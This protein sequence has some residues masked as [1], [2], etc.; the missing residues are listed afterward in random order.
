[1]AGPPAMVSRQPSACSTHPKTSVDGDGVT[2]PYEVDTPQPEPK[3]P[4][5][6]PK[7]GV[8]GHLV[9][10]LTRG[11]A[12]G[13]TDRSSSGRLPE[14]GGGFLPFSLFF[15]LN[16]MGWQIPIRLGTILMGGNPGTPGDWTPARKSH[17]TCPS[18]DFVNF[19][20]N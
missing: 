10:G 14:P 3:P 1:M 4:Q 11:V 15:D 8:G 13:T 5:P 9:H 20:G 2:I 12:G 18:P 6:P 17:R 16:P 19:T 7:D